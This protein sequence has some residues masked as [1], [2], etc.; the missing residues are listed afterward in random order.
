M[1]WL[2]AFSTSTRNSAVARLHVDTRFAIPMSNGSKKKYLAS[3]SPV[4]SVVASCNSDAPFTAL[5]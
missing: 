3:A 5:R 4:S 1:T 2:K